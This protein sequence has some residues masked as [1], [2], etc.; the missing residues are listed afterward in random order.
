MPVSEL[1]LIKNCMEFLPT[2]EV[3]NIPPYTRGIY[4]LFRYRHKSNRYEVVYIGMVGGINAGI[5]TRLRSHRRK[6]KGLWAHFSVFE[7]WDNIR[8]DEILELEGL[9]RHIYRKDTKANRLNKQK[10]FK[11]LTKVRLDSE[12][13]GWMKQSTPT[14]ASQ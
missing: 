9:F 3:D 7:V 6:K 10:A 2:V 4:V 14:T 13:A 5:R 1:R 8:E 12:R 11:K